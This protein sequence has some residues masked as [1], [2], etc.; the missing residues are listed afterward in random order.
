MIIMSPPIVIQQCQ[1][2]EI[3]FDGGHNAAGN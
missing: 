3:P 2:V 1:A